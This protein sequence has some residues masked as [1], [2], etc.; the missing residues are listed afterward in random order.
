MYSWILNIS[1]DGEPTNYLPG[2]SVL[3]FSHPH[4]KNC[5]LMFRGNLCFSLRPFPLALSLDSSAFSSHPPFRHLYTLMRF[6]WAFFSSRWTVPALPDT[7]QYLSWSQWTFA[8]L[9][10]L[11]KFFSCTGKHRTRHRKKRSQIF[12]SKNY[13]VSRHKANFFPPTAVLDHPFCTS[14]HPPSYQQPTPLRENTSLPFPGL[15]MLMPPSQAVTTTEVLRPHMLTFRW[16]PQ[17]QEDRVGRSPGLGCKRQLR[18]RVLTAEHTC[19]TVQ[20]HPLSD[21]LTLTL[22]LLALSLVCSTSNHD[23]KS[24]CRWEDRQCYIASRCSHSFPFT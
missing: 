20:D 17:V 10:P 12:L 4:S 9:H 14:S 2:Q 15:E 19:V 6:L 13:F 24:S 3:M 23:V 7:L 18:T 22:S 5:F 1:K 11:I 8:G 16:W 21:W